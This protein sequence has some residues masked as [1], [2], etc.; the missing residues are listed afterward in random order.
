MLADP[1]GS[2]LA[3]V[4][5]PFVRSPLS[6][7]FPKSSAM[8]LEIYD[9][10]KIYL[11]S[12]L[13]SLL[14]KG[15]IAMKDEGQERRG[16]RHGHHHH[17]HGGHHHRRRGGRAR[18][19][20]SKFLLMDALRDEPK[21]GYEIIKSLEELSGGQYAP[22]PGVVYPTLQFLAEAGLVQAE[23]DGD[24]RV[25]H[26]TDEGQRELAAHV[27]KVTDFWSQFAQPTAAAAR[28]EIGFIE[29]ELEYLAR[30][31]RGALRGDPET[32]LLR[33]VR[34]TIEN[35]R[36]EVRRLI[37]ASSEDSRS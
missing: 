24:R 32:E 5:E 17:D 12:T 31:V 6:V 35:C 22:S 1:P 25:F 8:T 16:G 7:R 34:L 14:E 20:E 2:S 21:H 9:N 11:Y 4:F 19:G 18:R 30:A 3:Y 13:Y 15:T 28:A 10:Y 27:D 29:E 37:A 33:R 36:N 26:L 23:E